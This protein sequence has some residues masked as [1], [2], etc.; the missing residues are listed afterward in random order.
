MVDSKDHTARRQNEEDE[1]G[2]QETQTPGQPPSHNLV[3]AIRQ[4]NHATQA[5][6]PAPLFYCN[7]QSCLQGVLEEGDQDYVT[8]V[9]LTPECIDE[10]VWWE[11]HLTVWNG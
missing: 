1:D 9:R 11:R 8:P 4:L 6:P 2:K 5:I 10:L 3:K 7:L